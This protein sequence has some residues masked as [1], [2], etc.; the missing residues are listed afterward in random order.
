[1]KESGLMERLYQRNENTRKISCF[2]ERTINR[3]VKA[4]WPMDIRK[5][6]SLYVALLI[7]FA[8]AL[9]ILL[10]EKLSM[11]QHRVEPP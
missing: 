5:T 7:G 9:M 11:R 6:F 3:I 1:M 10:V 2:N 4:P 8:I